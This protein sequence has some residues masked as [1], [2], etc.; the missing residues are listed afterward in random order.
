MEAFYRKIS[1][2]VLTGWIWCITGNTEVAICI[3]K[4]AS[5]SH[6]QSQHP[7]LISSPETASRPLSLCPLL[8]A[9]F[10]FTTHIVVTFVPLT[11][12]LL[13][14]PQ[15]CGHLFDI[16]ALRW[17]VSTICLWNY[18]FPALT[19][20]PSNPCSNL[21]SDTK[22]SVWW[23]AIYTFSGAWLLLFHCSSWR[24]SKVGH[25]FGITHCGEL[26]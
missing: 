15:L 14:Q 6:P 4:P 11:C 5:S 19:H 22:P 3:P 10:A 16:L 26:H 20:H 21:T 2:H 24:R 13:P 8:P 23:D 17:L 25:T 1:W 7:V 12:S 18:P 9:P